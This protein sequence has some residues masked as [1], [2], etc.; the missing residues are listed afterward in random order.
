MAR[1]GTVEQKDTFPRGLKKVCFNG[2]LTVAHQT[3]PE[4][5]FAVP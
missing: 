3:I 2:D 4:N 5:A 1:A